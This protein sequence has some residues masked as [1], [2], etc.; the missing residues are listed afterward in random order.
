M[1]DLFKSRAEAVGAE[2]R[3]FADRGQALDGVITALMDAGVKDER[4]AWAAWADEGCLR[5]EQ[6]RE[7][8]ARL[9]GVRFEVTTEVA[10]Q[11]LAGICAVEYGVAETGSLLSDS[12]AVERRL[13]STLPPVHIALLPVDRVV[14]SMAEALARFDPRKCSYLAAITGPSRTADIERVLTIGVH[15]P[16]RLLIFLIQDWDSL[17]GQP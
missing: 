5:A 2:C 15:G 3:L 6:R 16:R 8:L 7:V 12:S 13:V 4:G 11:S 17:E 10:E 1:I 14:P 9:P